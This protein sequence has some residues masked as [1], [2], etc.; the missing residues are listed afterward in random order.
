M[1]NPVR[2]SQ[3]YINRVANSKDILQYY[4]KKKLTEKSEPLRDVTN[5]REQ[6]CPGCARGRRG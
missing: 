6:E 3:E 5:G 4:R 2:F 1:I